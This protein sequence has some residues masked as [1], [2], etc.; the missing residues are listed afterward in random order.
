MTHRDNGRPQGE[1]M[2]VFPG[3]DGE[4]TVRVYSAPVNYYDAQKGAF[5]PVDNT[6][7]EQEENGRRYYTNRYND[8]KVRLYRDAD[9]AVVEKDAY[10]AE[11][12]FLPES[13]GLFGLRHGCVRRRADGADKRDG[14]SVV[15]ES[16]GQATDM[17]YSVADKSLKEDIIVRRPARGIRTGTGCGSQTSWRRRT[18]APYGCW[19]RTK[20]TDRRYSSS[21]RPL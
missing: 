1:N 10:A 9:I 6:L 17:A 14:D 8:F 20:R 7:V 19:R 13:A 15:Y 3:K 4:T 16:D 21:P 5:R 12:D 11:L 18:A 2:R